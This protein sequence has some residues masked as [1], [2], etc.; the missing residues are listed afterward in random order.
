M[1]CFRLSVTFQC[2]MDLRKFPMDVQTCFIRMESCKADSF[3]LTEFR[4]VNFH[5]DYVFAI[6][7]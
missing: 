7:G 5:S 3:L 1:T 2:L 4:S 6:L